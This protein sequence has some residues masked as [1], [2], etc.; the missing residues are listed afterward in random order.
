MMLHQANL[1]NDNCDAAK[2]CNPDGITANGQ[3]Q[4][5][6]PWNVGAYVAAVAGL[7]VGTILLL[8]NP[9]NA[10]QTAVDVSPNGSGAGL[11]LRSTF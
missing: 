2:V 4:G 11:M 1:R 6:A 7:G 5:L 10:R 8:T 3:L 9:R